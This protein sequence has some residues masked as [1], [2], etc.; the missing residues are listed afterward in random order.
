MGWIGE[1]VENGRV[2]HFEEGEGGDVDCFGVVVG[3]HL[4]AG[5]GE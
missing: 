2:A 3:R 1:R 4:R 5:R